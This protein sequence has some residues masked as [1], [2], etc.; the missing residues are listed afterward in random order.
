MAVIERMPKSGY[1]MREGFVTKLLVHTG[2]TVEKGTPLLEY[3]TDKLTGTV[4]ATSSGTVL[5]VLA[6]AEKSYPILCPLVVIGELG[7]K[8]TLE[9]PE[10]VKPAAEVSV[11]A[12]VAPSKTARAFATPRARKL[13]QERKIDLAEVPGTGPQGRIQG[14]DVLSFSKELPTATHLAGKLAH[15]QNLS[16]EQ[17]E[18][19]GPRGKVMKQDVQRTLNPAEK[20]PLRKERLSSMRKTIAARLTQSKQTIPHAYY[21]YDLEVDALEDIRQT[22]SRDSD[23]VKITYNDLLLFAVSR[24]LWKYPV[25]TARME[26]EQVV[27]A[28]GVNLGVAVSVNGGLVVPVLAD[29]QSLSL[30]ELSQKAAELAKQAK[31]GTLSPAQMSG[32]GFTVSNL[33]KYGVR[34]FSAIINP[35][36]AGILAIGAAEDRVCVVDGAVQIKKRMT[37]TLSADHR[38]IDG[39]EAAEFLQELNR[40]CR[41]PWRMML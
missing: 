37:V 28:E 31:E 2:D 7:E 6:E 33:G 29:A 41:E 8:I 9:E 22:L 14:K 21:T 11:K 24:T 13:A 39:A 15:Q 1:T 4:E 20:A 23:G 36:E 25:F 3:E 32:G 26:E 40:F 10:E 5:Q 30:G 17:V 34:Q 27:Y 19:T 38:L 16:L 35:P 18:G 12:D